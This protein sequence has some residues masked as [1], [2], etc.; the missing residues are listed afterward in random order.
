MLATAWKHR[1]KALHPRVSLW[2]WFVLWVT[3]LASFDIA[4]ASEPKLIVA[5]LVKA[6]VSSQT[7]FYV[8]IDWPAPVPAN[9]LLIVVGLP[10]SVTFSAGSASGSLWELPLTSLERL[11][12]VVP[13]LE[14]KRVNLSFYLVR[15][16]Q[17]GIVILASTRSVL[18]IEPSVRPATANPRN[19]NEPKTVEKSRHAPALDG[20]PAAAADEPEMQ[21]AVMIAKDQVASKEPGTPQA[22]DEKVIEAGR[23]LDEA[24]AKVAAKRAEAERLATEAARIEEARKAEEARVEEARRQIAER[25]AEAERLAAEAARAEEARKAEEAKVE[26]ARRRVAAQ[27]AETERL[28]AE[29]AS[30]EELR[31]AEGAKLEEARRQL[32]AGQAEAER[33]AVDME[34]VRKA[35]LAGVEEEHRRTLAKRLEAEHLAITA[36]EKRRTRVATPETASIADTKSSP[37]SAAASKTD[38]N[39]QPERFVKRGDEYLG[40][41]NVAVAREYFLR[42]SGAGVAIAALKL[43]ETYDPNE[44]AR[45]NVHGLLPN[46][47]EARRWYLRAL[48]LGSDEATSRLARL[49]D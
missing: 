41:G 1:F 37:S 49:G 11:K 23:A 17:S 31:K 29:A 3:T 5:P 35:E 39:A 8:N 45:M 40:Q 19:Q 44:L 36:A 38:G 43:A 10:K 9:S 47:G 24:R 30:A 15:K 46:A 25:R 26:Q 4:F 13:P 7:D 28:A 48:E 27:Q 12:I 22:A 32:V 14:P 18:A 20:R 16:Q 33:L 21:Q 42:A 6:E 2:R 34:Q